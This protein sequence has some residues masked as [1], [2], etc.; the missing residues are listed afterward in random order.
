MNDAFQ[1]IDA[2]QVPR[3][4]G[5]TTFMRLPGVAS[6]EGLDIAL[7]GIPWGCRER[8]PGLACSQASALPSSAS[9]RIA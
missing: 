8:I 6:A 3:F 7:A 4:A 5:P 1:P 9:R 2:A